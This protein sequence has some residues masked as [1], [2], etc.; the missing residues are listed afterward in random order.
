MAD[1][2]WVLIFLSNQTGVDLTKAL[3]KK[4]VKKNLRWVYEW[5]GWGGLGGGEE[6][7]GGE[8][9]VKRAGF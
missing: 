5:G 1:V 7:W 6:G 2:L 8:V 4:F 3:E 9:S